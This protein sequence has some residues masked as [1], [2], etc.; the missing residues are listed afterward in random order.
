MLVHPYSTH[1]KLKTT[2]KRILSFTAGETSVERAYYF[3]YNYVWTCNI[4][5]D[6]VPFKKLRPLGRTGQRESGGRYMKPRKCI[7]IHILTEIGK[8]FVLR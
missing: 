1:P 3:T 8:D 7:Q 4:N 6:R 2:Y 5:Y